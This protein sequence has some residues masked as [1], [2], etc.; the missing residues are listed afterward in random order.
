MILKIMNEFLGKWEVGVKSL[1]LY[2]TLCGPMNCN[3]P[4]SSFCL[5][6]SLGKNTRNG[7]PCPPSGDLLNSGVAKNIPFPSL[8]KGRG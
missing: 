4:D 8:V 7:L 3:P 2:P 5:R 6:D 1:E